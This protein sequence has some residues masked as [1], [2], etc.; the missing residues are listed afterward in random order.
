MHHRWL[1]TISESY[2]KIKLEQE[3]VSLVEDIHKVNPTLTEQEIETFI[4]SELKI[5]SRASLERG[6]VGKLKGKIGHAIL[7]VADKAPFTHALLAP[8][9]AAIFGGGKL[10]DKATTAKDLTTAATGVDPK[11]V[12]IDG[13][14]GSATPEG[15]RAAQKLSPAEQSARV[16]SHVRADRIGHIIRRLDQRERRRTGQPDSYQHDGTPI[17]DPTIG[18]QG[19]SKLERKFRERAA[20]GLPPATAAT[21]VQGGEV[22]GVTK[23]PMST[24]PEQPSKPKP[25]EQPAK[26]GRKPRGRR[27][28]Q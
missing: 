1:K 2:E 7:T 26:G 16:A 6:L 22:T 4:L 20:K 19:H 12:P 15:V 3:L 18:D 11:T 21:G 9:A 25:A 17:I 27:A 24:T 14:Y 28:K 13:P 8:A 23:M 5:P 10:P